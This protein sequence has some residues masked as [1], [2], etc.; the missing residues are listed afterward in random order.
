MKDKDTLAKKL[1]AETARIKWHELQP[2]FARGVLLVLASELD[3][4][5]TAVNFAEDCAEQLELALI[6]GEIMQPSNDQAR[7]WYQENTEFWAVVLA[8][9][10]L[11]QAVSA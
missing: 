6:S 10:V 11:I 1:H 5:E 2:H 4:I 7:H 8:P 9:Y 3:L